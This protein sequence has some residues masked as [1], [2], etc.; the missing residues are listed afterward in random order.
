MEATA[1]TESS[2]TMAEDRTTNDEINEDG[3]F[4]YEYVS[5]F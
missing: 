1:I 2:D 5:V 4:S 3:D